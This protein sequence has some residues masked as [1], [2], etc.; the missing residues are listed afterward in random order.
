MFNAR[1]V[2]FLWTK[3][4]ALMAVSLTEHVPGAALLAY[5]I[6]DSIPN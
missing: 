6:T 2:I 1:Q 5:P 3:Q 4:P